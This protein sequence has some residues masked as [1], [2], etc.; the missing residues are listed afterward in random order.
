MKDNGNGVIRVEIYYDSAAGCWFWPFEIIGSGNI[1][2]VLN[3][4]IGRVGKVFD[5]LCC[6][7][8]D[9]WA[10]RSP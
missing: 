4:P 5:L 9:G 2:P 10:V 6:F 1:F 7:M 8:A 3:H